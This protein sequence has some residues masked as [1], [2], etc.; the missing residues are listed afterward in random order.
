M[1]ENKF[2]RKDQTL[3]I[4]AAALQL[5]EAI[6]YLAIMATI[7]DDRP[8]TQSSEGV[9]KMIAQLWGSGFSDRGIIEE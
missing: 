6:Q 8:Q 4:G 3:S 9:I 5:P 7:L 1:I 2:T